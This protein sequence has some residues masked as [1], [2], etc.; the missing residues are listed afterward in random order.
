MKRKDR[1]TSVR[2]GSSSSKQNNENER[3]SHKWTPDHLLRPQSPPHAPEVVL[4]LLRT[5]GA[6]V[7]FIYLYTQ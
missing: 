5:R 3:V 4:K 2:S 6:K 1:P 7:G